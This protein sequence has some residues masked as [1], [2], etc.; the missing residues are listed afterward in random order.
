MKVLW[1]RKTLFYGILENRLN[2]QVTKQFKYKKSSARRVNGKKGKKLLRS[3]K[4]TEKFGFGSSKWKN[5]KMKICQQR[6]GRLRR[7]LLTTHNFQKTWSFS[8]RT[9]PS[10]RALTR[11]LSI[12]RTCSTNLIGADLGIFIS[13]SK[14]LPFPALSLPPSS[15]PPFPFLRYRN[16][17]IPPL[18]PTCPAAQRAKLGV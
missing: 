13:P 12:C 17:H 9:L 16:L 4:V 14:N 2:K 8:T 6:F 1:C 10:L 15:F 18:P 7:Q 3:P 11:I 5:E